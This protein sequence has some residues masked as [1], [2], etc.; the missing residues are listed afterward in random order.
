MSRGANAGFHLFIFLMHAKLVCL[1]SSLSGSVLERD[2]LLGKLL[3]SWSIGGN[4]DL[5]GMETREKT[6]VGV[7]SSGCPLCDL[8]A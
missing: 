4:E 8:V 3:E 5:G 6:P 7:S 2:G 1:C